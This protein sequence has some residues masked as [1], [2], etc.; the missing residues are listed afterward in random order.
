[1]PE[2]R[3]PAPP[4]APVK[5]RYYAALEDWQA[6]IGTFSTTR[7]LLAEARTWL[8]DGP[9]AGKTARDAWP[10]G[11]GDLISRIDH[12]L[13]VNF[14]RLSPLQPGPHRY[15]R[16]RRYR[17]LLRLRRAGNR[18]EHRRGLR[19]LGARPCLAPA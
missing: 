5:L 16:G 18:R 8:G 15:R 9:N 2:K 6:M 13:S 1:M 10:A 11:L 19:Q 3:N 7:G 14:A 12:N 17:P 4:A